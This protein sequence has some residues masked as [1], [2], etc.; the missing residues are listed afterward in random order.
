MPGYRLFILILQ[1]WLIV[2]LPACGPHQEGVFVT[3]VVDPQE[4]EIEFL[5]QDNDGKPLKS[6]K[7]LRNYV[8]ENG[9]ELRF[10]VE[11]NY[12]QVGIVDTPNGLQSFGPSHSKTVFRMRLEPV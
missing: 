10:R 8:E 5:W 9:K 6:I 3:F 1:I 12:L 4:A 7:N 11:P 2:L